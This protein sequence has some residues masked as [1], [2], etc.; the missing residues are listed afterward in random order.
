VNR[1]TLLASS[2]IRSSGFDLFDELG[3][4]SS[5]TDTVCDIIPEF[6]GRNCY[7]AFNKPNPETA[8]NEDY[9]SINLIG[10]Q[11]ESVFEHASATF[12]VVASRD[13]LLEAER[14][15]HL[16]WSVFSTRYVPPS[17]MRYGLHPGTPDDQEIKDEIER[18]WLSSLKLYD[19]IYKRL[20]EDGKSIK[21]ARE[22]ARQVLP[23]NTQTMAVVTGNM[24]A[25]RYVINLRSAEGAD[26]EFRQISKELLTELKSIAPNTFQDMDI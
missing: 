12:V 20:R 10:K 11:H 14:H 4:D 16:S 1:V 5:L 17:K 15:R 22:A 9:L 24:R 26:E 8:S 7:Q 3:F 23:G 25:W 13:W 19:R 21:Q 2:T 18:Q 6:A